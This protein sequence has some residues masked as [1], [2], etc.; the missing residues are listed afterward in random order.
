MLWKKL[1]R[2]GQMVPLKDDPMSDEYLLFQ[3]SVAHYGPGP[4]VDSLMRFREANP[5]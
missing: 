5:T 1:R 3:S 2:N 4:M